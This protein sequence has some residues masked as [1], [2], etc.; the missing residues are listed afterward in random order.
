[1]KGHFGDYTWISL[2]LFELEDLEINVAPT[3][4]SDAVIGLPCFAIAVIITTHAA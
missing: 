4:T 2:N 3:G 1:L